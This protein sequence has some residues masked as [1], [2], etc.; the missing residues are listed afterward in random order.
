MNPDEIAD[1]AERI[2][3]IAVEL[4]KQV[5]TP[6][7]AAAVTKVMVT[8][9]LY[10]AVMGCILGILVTSAVVC[11]KR[12]AGF[13]SAIEDE[14]KRY[15]RAEKAFYKA[16]AERQIENNSKYPYFDNP[17][18]TYKS[19]KG[20]DLRNKAQNWTVGGVLLLLCIIPVVVFVGHCL[21]RV[22][23]AEYWAFLLVRNMLMGM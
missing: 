23:S 4:V 2:A 1:V 20:N 12:C 19:Y 7:Y 16:R 14:K 8:N 21:S 3:A 5:A 10:M 22:M 15:D 17:F 9:Q 13:D 18:D 6:I 11:F